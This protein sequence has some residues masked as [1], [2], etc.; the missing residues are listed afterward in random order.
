M[1]HRY[2]GEA[3]AIKSE[4]DNKTKAGVVGI[5]NTDTIEKVMLSFFFFLER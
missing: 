2:N 4:A 5:I 1:G 3:K